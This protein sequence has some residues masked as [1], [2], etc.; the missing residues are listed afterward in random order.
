MIAQDVVGAVHLLQQCFGL[1][2][3]PLAGTLEQIR[4]VRPHQPPIGLL[5][6]SSAGSRL[7]L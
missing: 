7:N 6:L 3:L 4:V 5:N 1:L 2:P